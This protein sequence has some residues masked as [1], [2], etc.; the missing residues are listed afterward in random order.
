MVA[1]N[2][3]GVACSGAQ[4]LWTTMDIHLRHASERVSCRDARVAIVITDEEDG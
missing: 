1:I 2:W 3:S 4:A